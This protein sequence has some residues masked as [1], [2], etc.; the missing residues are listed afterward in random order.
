[1]KRAVLALA[2][3]L[4]ATASPAFAG[5]LIIRVL[6]EGGSGSGGSGGFDPSY[7]PGAGSPDGYDPDGERGSRPMGSLPPAPK[8]PGPSGPGPSIPF[9]PGP[10]TTTTTTTPAIDHTRSIVIVVPL[11]TKLQKQVLDPAR[12]HHD[13]ANP[14]YNK[15]PLDY[16]GQKYKVSLFVDSTSIQLYTDLLGTPGPAQHKGTE[17]LAKYDSWS[18]KKEDPQLLYAAMIMALENGFVKEALAYGN[19]LLA[20][21]NEKKLPLSQD[22]QRFV[23]AWAKMGPKVNARPTKAI[24]TETWRLT[25]DAT[26]VIPT[27]H[28]SLLIWDN[29]QAEYSRRAR[30]LD[31]HFDA[32]FLW[33]ATQG[34]VLP[35]PDH[36]LLVVLAK[37]ES[38]MRKHFSALDG[39]SGLR[40]AFYSSN[41]GVLVLSPEPRDPVPFT[42]VRQ[43][44]QIFVKGLNRN[45]LLTGVIPKF[46]FNDPRGI[47]PDDVARATTLALVEKMAIDDVET[48]AV[49][50]EGTRQ[51]LHATGLLPGHVVL[52]AWLTNGSVNFFMRPSAPAYIT[53]GEAEKP[54]MRVALTTGYGVPNYVLQRYFHDML[55]KSELSPIIPPGSKK[56][57]GIDS[58]RLLENILTDAYFAGIKDGIDPDPSLPPKPKKPA[59]GTAVLPGPGGTDPGPVAPGPGPIRPGGPGPTMPPGAAGEGSG[60]PG[61]QGILPPDFEDPII[62]RRKKRDRLT[63][64]AQATS[65]ALYYYLATSNQAGD[66][67]RYF[68]ELNQLPRDLPIDGKTALAVFVRV[69]KLSD[70]EGGP[71]NPEKMKAFADAWLRYMQTIPKAYAGDIPL[72][73]PEPKKVEP[74]TVPGGMP[75]GGIGMPPGG[76]GR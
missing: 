17:L 16:H 15:F 46:D 76:M 45:Q 40:D 66:L 34:V 41:N 19:E 31:E 47:R 58:A 37:R 39:M 18:R 50:R 6:L 35:V 74:G 54:H 63:L 73:V 11:T 44:H 23:D 4:T 67:R 14:Y 26:E 29:P 38:D 62:T 55:D 71:P 69:F 60:Y 1:M 7:Y 42:F 33:H 28:Y 10:G 72:V 43:N 13:F 70:T 68:D 36:P 51:L 61:Y 22:A 56:A 57:T 53:I 32:F 2:V 59:P 9:G 21:A 30:Q 48:A 8:G 52:P 49:S 24:D 27:R 64:K 3:L 5:Y 65:W 25:L 20:V 12:V 75:P